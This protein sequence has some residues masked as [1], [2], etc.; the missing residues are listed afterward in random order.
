MLDGLV[1]TH[2]KICLTFANTVAVTVT[3]KII[4]ALK[5]V[6]K[7]RQINYKKYIYA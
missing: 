1:S 6:V 3:L 4:V 5:I 7:L 2:P